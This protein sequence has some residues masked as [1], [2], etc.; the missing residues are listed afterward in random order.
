[1][2]KRTYYSLLLIFLAASAAHAD[3]WIIGNVNDANDCTDSDGRVVHVYY[4]GDPDNYETCTV[5]EFAPDDDPYYM[6]NTTTIPEHEFSLGDTLI[7][8]VID[9]GDGYTAGPISVLTTGIG[10]TE[11]PIMN[12]TKDG[13]ATDPDYPNCSDCDADNIT[14]VSD[15]CIYTANHTQPDSDTDGI[16]DA[17]DK[18]DGPC[19]CDAVNLDGIDPVDIYDL[20]YV[21]D[22]WTFEAPAA[23][24]I[25][26]IN[27]DEIVNLT[28]FAIVA[29]FWLS[30]C[31]S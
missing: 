12:L 4:P 6:C 23:T 2:R 14:D 1:M 5:G 11:A 13:I 18:C 8:E 16:G 24:L 29:E 15:N 19:P 20:L 28:D 31:G 27:G 7:V 30:T 22:D 17:C 25:G 10:W 26:D 21:V 9:T 3:Y